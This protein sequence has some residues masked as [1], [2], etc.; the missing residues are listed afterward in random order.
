MGKFEP[1]NNYLQMWTTVKIFL[2]CDKFDILS[3]GRPF[4]WHD[5]WALVG[6]LGVYLFWVS[7]LR[8]VVRDR[9]KQHPVGKNWAGFCLLS[10]EC[11]TKH[12]QQYHTKTEEEGRT[13]NGKKVNRK[14]TQLYRIYENC[15]IGLCLKLGI[16]TFSHFCAFVN[17][18]NEGKRRAQKNGP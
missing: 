11:R 12:H 14:H 1:E 18:K 2:A 13:G 3:G 9:I 5:T 16:K 7:F 17:P 8:I 15:M 6:T 4:A 10:Q